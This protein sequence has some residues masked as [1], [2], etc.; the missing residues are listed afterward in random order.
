[1]MVYLGIILAFVF[2]GVVFYL[3][4]M[5][6]MQLEQKADEDVLRAKDSYQKIIDQKMKTLAERNKLEREAAQ[7][8][9]LYEMTKDITR[10]FNE[11]EAFDIFKRKLKESIAIEDCRMVEDMPSTDEMPQGYAAFPLKS[12]DKKLGFLLYKGVS[13]RDKDKFVI[14]AHQFALAYLRIKLYHDV[15]TMAITDALTGVYTRRYF[16]ERFEEEKE[17]SKM[18]KAK[19]S[20]L[21][22]DAD[23]FKAVNDAHGHLAGDEVLRQIASVL[24]ESV[25][26]ID[27]VGRY[28]GEEFCVVLPDTDAEGA[29]LVAERIRKSMEGKKIKAYDAALRITLSIGLCTYPTDGKSAEELIDKADWALYRAKSAGRNCVI[30]FGEYNK[31]S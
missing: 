26:E 6:V 2:I 11:D 19:M 28:G 4:Q 20:F 5:V 16:M 17:R 22:V 3:A 7:I 21:L 10:H 13:D 1:M 14:L 23:H 31:S 25:R 18:R 9:T 27:I 8:F 12:K 30:A 15:E 29:L 24:K